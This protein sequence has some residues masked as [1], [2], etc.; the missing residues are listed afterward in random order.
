MFDLA[1]AFFSGIFVNC[2]YLDEK[3]ILGFFLGT[4]LALLLYVSPNTN[5]DYASQGMA[6]S[7]ALKKHSRSVSVVK[8]WKNR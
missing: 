2:Q 8:I 6:I 7:C 4:Y 1:G 3:I 5:L